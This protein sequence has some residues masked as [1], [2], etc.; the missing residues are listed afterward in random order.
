M[1]NP[2]LWVAEHSFIMIIVAIVKDNS[3]DDISLASLADK[4]YPAGHQTPPDHSTWPSTPS[5]PSSEDES[6][7]SGKNIPIIHHMA[8]T[9]NHYPQMKTLMGM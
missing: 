2:L 1:K 7:S 6:D 8:A 9:W 3:I 5:S 4:N